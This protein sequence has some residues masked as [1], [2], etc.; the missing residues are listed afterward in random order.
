MLA[1]WTINSFKAEATQGPVMNRG[2]TQRR[3]SFEQ[4]GYRHL[5]YS[6]WQ[7]HLKVWR[8]FSLAEKPS[9]D[10]VIRENIIWALWDCLSF[11]EH[12]WAIIGKCVKLLPVLKWKESAWMLRSSQVSLME[13]QPGLKNLWEKLWH[14]GEIMM[15]LD[16]M[17]HHMLSARLRCE[18][19]RGSA[20]GC[21]W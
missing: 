16:Y 11:M 12:S 14:S 7:A 8:F 1:A 17:H 18:G 15:F 10:S 13:E 4:Y 3:K 9:W 20:W 6:P 5:V 21:L 2:R 19:H